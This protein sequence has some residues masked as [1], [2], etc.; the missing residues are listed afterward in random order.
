MALYEY[1]TAGGILIGKKELVT[2]ESFC[3][4]FILLNYTVTFSLKIVKLLKINTNH[5]QKM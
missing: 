3:I 4:F 5:L 1:E 2:S